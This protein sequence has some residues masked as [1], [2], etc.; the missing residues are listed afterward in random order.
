MPSPDEQVGTIDPL[1][2]AFCSLPAI[3]AILDSCLKSPVSQWEQELPA[4]Q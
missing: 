4:S 1:P 2:F 3:L